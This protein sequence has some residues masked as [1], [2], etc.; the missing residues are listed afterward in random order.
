MTTRSA[1]PFAGVG[2]LKDSFAL[3]AKRPGTLVGAALLLLVTTLVPSLIT[4][5]LQLAMPGSIPVLIGSFALSVIVGVLMVPLM[6]GY[7]QM[8]DRI[9]RGQA[10]AAFDIYGPYRNG[11]AVPLI[12]FALLFFVVFIAL[13]ALVLAAFGG[14]LVQWYASI[15]TMGPQA[16]AAAPPP[17]GI[18]AVFVAIFVFSFFAMGITSIGYGQVAIGGQRPLA[19]FRDGAVG[20]IR[21]I[22]PLIVLGFVSALLWIGVCLVLGIV[23]LLLNFLVGAENAWMMIVVLPIYIGLVLLIYPIMFGVMYHFWRDVCGQ[24]RPNAM[25][26]TLA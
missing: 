13:L 14:S 24:D 21:N 4:I 22:V 26:Q 1:A 11:G 15:L 20:T 7:L 12:L 17:S 10:A 5:P 23:V 18:W 19:A 8:L 25:A 6:G 9:E 2:W 16:Q 3:I